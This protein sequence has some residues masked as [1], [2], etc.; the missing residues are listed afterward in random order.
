MTAAAAPYRRAPKPTATD[1]G[2]G[3]RPLEVGITQALAQ[4]LALAG[5][6]LLAAAAGA[7]AVRQPVFTLQGID[8][9]GELTR[10]S[11]AQV[12]TAAVPRLQGNF[13]TLDLEAAQAAFESVPWVRTAQVRRVWP[14][15][16][17]VRIDE[18]RPAALW[19]GADGERL[20][21]THGEVFE[22]NAAA[23][24][25]VLP[26][27]A[28]PDGSSARM[29]ALYRALIDTLA[30]L[31]PAIDALTLTSRGS[32]TVALD[33]GVTLELGR[34]SDAE[35]LERTHRF[36]ATVPELVARFGRP[37]AHADLRHRDGYALKLTGL[38]TGPEAGFP[39]PRP[40]AART[41]AA[42]SR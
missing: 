38:G 35:V 7:W 39:T 14:N 15:R 20:V 5:A 26:T 33:N 6:L 25:E 24:D 4:A 29:L 41:P 18:H 17:H 34:G 36:V 1:R 3:L 40:T 12:R 10:S 13:F 22:A 37:L 16:L 27:L 21:N 31:G 23:V 28:G 8:L 42:P 19:G 30:P 2:A 9:D 32:W 11:L